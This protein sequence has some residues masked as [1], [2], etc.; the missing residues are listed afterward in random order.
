MV[1]KQ[2]NNMKPSPLTS[3]CSRQP[4]AAFSE[5]SQS[6]VSIKSHDLPLFNQSETSS[7][8]IVHGELSTM[9]RVTHLV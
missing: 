4:T 5:S 3:I 7:L 8:K 1:V 9:P 2:D 6:E